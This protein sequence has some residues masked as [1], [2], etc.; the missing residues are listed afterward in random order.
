MSNSKGGV[1]NM[2]SSAD[3]KKNQNSY[4]SIITD[5]V[6]AFTEI[7]NPPPKKQRGLLKAYRFAVKDVFDIQG[8]R[9]QAGNPHYYKYANQAQ[10]TAPAI[11]TLQAEGAILVGKTHT[12]ELGGSL[13][14]L[15]FHYGTPLNTQSPDRVPGGSSSGSAAAVA[16]GLVDFAL[17]ADTSGSVRAPASFCGIYGFR[18]TLGA[19]PTSGV[20]PISS[21]LDTVGL[22]AQHPLVIQHVLEAYG[23]QRQNAP[24]RLRIIP[25]LLNVLKEPIHSSFLEKLNAIK[26][27]VPFGAD[28][29]LD[30][31]LLTGWS[32][33]IRTIAMHDLWQV[34]KNWI[35]E[36][37]PTFGEII[38]D[39]ITIA[40]SILYE[41][42][43][44]ALHEQ[45]IIQKFLE[46]NLEAG[47]IAIF[48]TVHDIPPLLSSS[49]ADLR[50]FSLKAS[51]HTC[52]ASLAGFPEI[53]VP[54][55]NVKDGCSLGM[56]FLGRAGD[57]LSLVSF[58][59][60]VHTL[61]TKGS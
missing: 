36:E 46:D 48:P 45:K 34:H 8:F 27:L 18:P 14:G 52:I 19:I 30:G 17:G 33:V 26:A 57:D 12:D 15:N 40:K 9:V 3:T 50:D 5:S 22:F 47:D 53:S 56:S 59:G 16:A 49:T 20:L 24:K 13:F 54:L 28:L 6:N 41:D 2:V 23:M 29:I 44:T 4:M 32:T 60:Q 38:N 55:K 1:M 42:Y 43:K 11:A 10:Q 7:I 31:D 51:R 35:L 21:H 37:N 61:L 25:S 39:R 58:A